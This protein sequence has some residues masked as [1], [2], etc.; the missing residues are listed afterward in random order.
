MRLL[1]GGGLR[2]VEDAVTTAGVD[3]LSPL[4]QQPNA[5]VWSGRSD[6]ANA[7]LR[8]SVMDEGLVKST[9]VSWV[10]VPPAPAPPRT[11]VHRLQAEFY[12]RYM[13]AVRIAHADPPG[14]LPR[15]ERLILT[16]GEFEADVNNGG[17]GQFLFNKGRRRATETVRAL[18]RI[19]APKTA[20]MLASALAHPDDDTRLGK[21][22][23]RFY[24]V[25]EDLA[26]KTML[27]VGAGASSTRGARS[28]ATRS[29]SSRR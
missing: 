12:D 27:S 19:R 29:P 24:E 15:A 20:A 10:V 25:P 4:V 26:V 2:S 7:D 11:R 9:L 14:R 18:K 1:H 13:A 22:A 3:W 8:I 21:L 16:I 5:R 6:K 28:R 17:F 23:D